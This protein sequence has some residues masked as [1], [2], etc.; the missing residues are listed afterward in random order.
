MIS[1]DLVGHL[2]FIIVALSLLMR[3][4][5]WLRVI[6]IISGIIGITYNFF[7]PFGPLWVPIIWLTIFIIINIFMIAS[8]YHSNRRTGFTEKEMTI[9]RKTFWG[10]SPEE[11]RQLIKIIKIETIPKNQ[12][13]INYGEETKNIYFILSGKL[14]VFVS[15]KAIKVLVEGDIAG[16]M[17][18]INETTANAQVKTT[19]ISEC[20]LLDKNKLKKLMIKYP[21]FNIS[22][23]NIFNKN[24]VKKITP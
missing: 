9:W 7:L 8:F 19:D 2:S 6:S 15:G 12:V 4:I 16:E 21:S 23:T 1:I 18:F 10:L 17:S 14:T 20:I 13:I 5:I 3:D 22:I 11:F 24:L